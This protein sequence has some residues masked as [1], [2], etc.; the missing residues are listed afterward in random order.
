MQKTQKDK[1][2]DQMLLFINI[3]LM[4]K[5]IEEKLEI[6]LI[7]LNKNLIEKQRKNEDFIK[8]KKLKINWTNLKK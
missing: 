8:F 2:F 1:L 7:L 3:C 5:L 4:T 6:K